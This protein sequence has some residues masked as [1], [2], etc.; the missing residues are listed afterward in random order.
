MAIDHVI[1]TETALRPRAPGTYVVNEVF[2]SLQGEG[3]LAG[4]PMV[5]V[6]FSDCNLRC[7]VKAAGFDCDTE[8]VSGR[9]LDA[10]A[11]VA[12]ARELVPAD[13]TPRVLF[14]GGEPAL[15]L[16]A[17]LL[18]AFY[19]AGWRRYAIETNGTID[20]SVRLAGASGRLHVCVS[21]KSAEHTLRQLHADE[22]KYVR[23]R[24]QALPESRVN[25]GHHLVS[26]AARADGSFDRE[27]V[28][29]CV[30]LVKENPSWRLSLQLHKILGVR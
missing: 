7:T 21:P 19:D 23:H 13:E 24:G 14:T 20:L 16:D 9:E 30:Q 11:I 2:Y 26:P 4:E 3:V 6:R 12:A 1:P 15:Q 10:A 27:D 22:V 8:F 29:W 17:A 5:F 28:A 18:D 25:A